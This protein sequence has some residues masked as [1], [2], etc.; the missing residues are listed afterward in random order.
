MVVVLFLVFLV[1]RGSPQWGTPP[2]CGIH[3]GR[4]SGSGPCAPTRKS[5]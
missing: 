4:W 5:Y 2:T 1:G 3:R